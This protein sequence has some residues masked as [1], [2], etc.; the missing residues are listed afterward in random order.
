MMLYFSQI[1][2]LSMKFSAKKMF[3]ASLYFASFYASAQRNV[4]LTDLSPEI[5][6]EIANPVITDARD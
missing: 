6:L 4:T 3:T 2:E 5:S 1:K